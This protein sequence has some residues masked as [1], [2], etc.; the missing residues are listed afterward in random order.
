MLRGIY[1][2]FLNNNPAKHNILML[3]GVQKIKED[4]VHIDEF[5]TKYHDANWKEFRLL[6][7]GKI[8]K[9]TIEGIHF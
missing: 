3:E 1:E 6:L 5:R 7:P 4:T 8:E 9:H 2:E